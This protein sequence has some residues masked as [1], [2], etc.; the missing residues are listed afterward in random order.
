[1][2]RMSV[3]AAVPRDAIVVQLT[4][5]SIP[6]GYVSRRANERLTFVPSNQACV[7]DASALHQRRA[8]VGLGGNWEY[9]PQGGDLKHRRY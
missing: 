7:D 6:Q 8:S 2:A 3:P 1:M 4:V 5:P 9:R